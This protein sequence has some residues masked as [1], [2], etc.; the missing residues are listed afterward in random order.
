MNKTS[1]AQTSRENVQEIRRQHGYL[2]FCTQMNYDYDKL[3]QVQILDVIL[4]STTVGGRYLSVVTIA[5]FPFSYPVVLVTIF[6]AFH[7]TIAQTDY[8]N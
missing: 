2:P 8:S 1:T 6:P 4:S 3:A 7:N 5:H